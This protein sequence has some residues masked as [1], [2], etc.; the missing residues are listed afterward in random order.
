MIW[1]MLMKVFST[2]LQIVLFGRQ[3]EQ[4]KDLEILLLRRQLAILERHHTQRIQVSRPDKLTLTVLA[5][6]LRSASGW[7]RQRLRMVLHIVQPET[8]FK[9][10]RELVRRKW[11]FQQP[12]RGGRP[13][14]ARDLEQLIVRPARDKPGWGNARIEGELT[15]LG[16]ALSDETVAT[17]LKRHGIPPAPQRYSSLSWQNLMTYYRDQILARDF[18]TVET[19]FLHTIYVLFYIE[20][21]TRRVYVAGCMTAP[22]SAWVVQQARQLSWQLE[23]RTPA[24]HFL[25]HD[26]DSKF[27][28]AFDTVFRGQAVYVILTPCRAP[29]ANAVA[30]RWCE[31]YARSVWTSC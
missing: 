10:H 30:E 2:I 14:T 26:H 8:V 25:I 13:R 4:E 1:F 17:I 23:G 19:L 5:S 15:K 3:S 18:F 29:N 12:S 9:W 28:A 16:Y 24:I 27:T 7:S 31:R 11:T 20:L 21:S 22:T 6:H